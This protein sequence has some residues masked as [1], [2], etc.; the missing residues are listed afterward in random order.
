MIQPLI[1]KFNLCM[2]LYW[3]PQVKCNLFF[4]TL[5]VYPLFVMCACIEMVMTYV[6]YASQFQSVHKHCIDKDTLVHT[7]VIMAYVWSK[8]Q[9]F[10][11]SA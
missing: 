11:V 6:T 9:P 1:L 5:H 4:V 8:F 3:A 2:P 10:A 7:V